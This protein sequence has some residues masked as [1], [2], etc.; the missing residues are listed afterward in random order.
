MSPFAARARSRPT[1]L[2]AAGAVAAALLVAC[3]DAAQGAASPVKRVKASVHDDFNGD[4]FADLAV[5]GTRGTVGGLKDAGYAAVMYGG[6]H[7]LSTTRRAVISR[8][9]P[10]VPGAPVE[11]QG[12]GSALS[13]GDLDGDGY[14]DLV[15]GGI[16]GKDSV[17]VWGSESGLTGGTSVPTYSTLSQVGDFD[18]DGHTDV[19]LFRTA[20]TGMDDPQGTD[21]VIWYG[22]VSRAGSPART[23][24]FG[25]EST[26]FT[27]VWSASSGDVN[28]DGFADLAIAEYHGEGG[29]STELYFGSAQGL[30]PRNNGGG[31]PGYT[32]S[33]VLGD[34]NGDGYDDFI[35][36]DDNER[37]DVVY[38]SRSGLSSRTVTVSQNTPGVPGAAEADDQFGHV[39]AVGDVTG[40]GI[41][42]LA[43]GVPGEDLGAQAKPGYLSTV[44]AVAVLR[45]SKS[46]LTG[47]GSQLFTQ[48]T[49]GVPGSAEASDQLGSAVRLVDVNGNGYADLA[50]AALGEDGKNGAVT[51]LRGRPEGITTDAALLF[52][53]KA[54][55]APAAKSWFGYALS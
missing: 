36:G 32:R 40:D 31:T 6:P 3:T 25:A 52:G 30:S 16:G 51:L 4:G 29:N 42:D 41:D 17:I 50:V 43:V 46:G 9:T 14:A 33:A 37:V 18:G 44:G 48:N 27:E 28:G 38:G 10:G 47:A 13:H 54:I 22:P 55:G 19:A 34:V 53:P 11:G 23:S 35:A 12:F 2:L 7:G 8:G 24:Q 26:K 45:G 49:A 5:S 20:H 21:S 1:A 39:L 15:I